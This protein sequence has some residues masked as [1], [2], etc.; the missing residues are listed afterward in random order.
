MDIPRNEFLENVRYVRRFL[1][2]I[3]HAS[4][5]VFDSVIKPICIAK[6]NI[7][8]IV[9]RDTIYAKIQKKYMTQISI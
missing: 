6:L 9:N 5:Y 8:I 2:W 1:S 3:F 7:E 4:S